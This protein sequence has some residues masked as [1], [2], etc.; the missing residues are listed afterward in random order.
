MLRKVKPNDDLAQVTS[1]EHQSHRFELAIGSRIQVSAL[2]E[3]GFLKC[4]RHMR[5]P[6]RCDSISRNILYPLKSRLLR[7]L[8]RYGGVE[9]FRM[10]GALTLIRL[11]RI[12]LCFGAGRNVHPQQQCTKQSSG[13]PEP[14]GNP[15]HV[16]NGES[17]DLELL[18]K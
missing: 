2:V 3:D 6:H 10:F 5:L 8:L 16:F 1:G 17:I 13:I 11:E 18:T 15:C 7:E 9:S 4:K 14:S 12:A